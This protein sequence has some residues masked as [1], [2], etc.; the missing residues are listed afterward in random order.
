MVRPVVFAVFGLLVGSFLTVVTHRI[1]RRETVVAGRSKC[2]SCGST[3]RARDNVP[4]FSYLLLRGRCRA[5][6]ARISPEY[7]LTELST[8]LLAAGA[9]LRFHSL[10]VAAMVASFLAVLLALALID[11]RHRM[12]PNRIVYP[13][14]IAFGVLIAVGDMAGRGVDLATAA[15]GFAAFGGGLLLIALVSPRGMGMGDVKLAF[16][17]GLVLGSL[18]LS[19]VAVAAG[20]AVLA[21]GLGALAALAA[22][23]SRKSAIPFGPYLAL[24]ATVAAFAGPQISHSY[25]RLFGA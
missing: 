23:R 18:A 19:F 25:L 3:I 8:A 11:T 6:G 21:G 22:G 15:V 10:L 12:L 14:A 7:P 9:S 13:S 24:G 16:L 4:L 20:V 1:P 5:C 2:R 17:I